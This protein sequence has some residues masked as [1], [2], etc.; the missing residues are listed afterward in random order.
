MLALVTSV[1]WAKTRKK[2]R[3]TLRYLGRKTL[4]SLLCAYFGFSTLFVAV[5]VAVVAGGGPLSRAERH[6][7]VF[8]CTIRSGGPPRTGS[9]YHLSLV[10]PS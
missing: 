6:L 4:L 8:C 7:I 10:L 1:I 3:T 5:E 2:K 9:F